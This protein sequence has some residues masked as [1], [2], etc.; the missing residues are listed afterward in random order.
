MKLLLVMIAFYAADTAS[1]TKYNQAVEKTKE[2]LIEQSGM[3][4]GVVQTSEVVK[5]EAYKWA[6][7]NNVK[8]IAVGIVGAATIV[9]NRE[10]RWKISDSLALRGNQ[11]EVAATWT[12]KF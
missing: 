1:N 6:D 3:K 4:A 2:A 7:K 11:R 9:Y 10:I 5:Q 8:Y 12:I